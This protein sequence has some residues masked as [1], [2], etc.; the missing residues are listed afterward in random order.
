[1]YGCADRRSAAIKRGLFL[2]A[3]GNFLYCIA[4]IMERVVNGVRNSASRS[5]DCSNPQNLANTQITPYPITDI[6]YSLSYN[7]IASVISG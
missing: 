4:A 3:S 5:G 1:M 2:L 6:K 7:Q